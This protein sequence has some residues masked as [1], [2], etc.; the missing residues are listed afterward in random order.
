MTDST[1]TA[2]SKQTE[3]SEH[4]NQLN[5]LNLNQLNQLNQQVNQQAKDPN[6]LE[7]QEFQPE[8][9]AVDQAALQARRRTGEGVERINQA[10]D[11]ATEE[12]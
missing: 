6:T 7:Q 12:A 4:L 3:S 10:D 1:N 5:Q 9:G 8:S 11:T 2:H